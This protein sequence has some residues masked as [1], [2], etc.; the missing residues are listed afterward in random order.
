MNFPQKHTRRELSRRFQYKIFR[1]ISE[2]F[3]LALN[4]RQSDKTLRR[5]EAARSRNRIDKQMCQKVNCSCQNDIAS[6]RDICM[7]GRYAVYKKCQYIILYIRLLYDFIIT[8]FWAFSLI[9]NW[10]T[11]AAHINNRYI[12]IHIYLAYSMQSNWTLWGE[13]ANFLSN[14]TYT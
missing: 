1:K 9:L 10:V 4:Q 7:S 5:T 2:N 11:D 3:T 14:A 6:A 12:H 8:K 13:C